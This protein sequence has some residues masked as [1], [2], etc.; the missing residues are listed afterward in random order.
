MIVVMFGL[1]LVL[2]LRL[3]VRLL[4]VLAYYI[5]S[6]V[7][8]LFRGFVLLFWGGG[9]LLFWVLGGQLGFVICW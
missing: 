8:L 4:I 1:G 6:G 9:Y 3:V 2:L 5:H 7:S